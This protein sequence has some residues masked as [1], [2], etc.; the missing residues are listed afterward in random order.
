MAS[1]VWGIAACI[2]EKSLDCVDVSGIA[3]LKYYYEY[4]GKAHLSGDTY[5]LVVDVPDGLRC[6]GQVLPTRAT[7]TP[8]TRSRWPARSTP[9]TTS[10][11]SAVRRERSSGPSRCNGSELHTPGGGTKPPSSSSISR[12]DGERGAVLEIRPDDLDAHRQA[13]RGATDGDD[14]GGKVGQRRQRHPAHHV[15]V[16]P[17]A[18]VRPNHPVGERLAVV[19][20]DGGHHRHR[21]QQGVHVARRTP[22]SARAAARV[23]RWRTPNRGSAGWRSAPCGPAGRRRRRAVSPPAPPGCRIVRWAMVDSRIG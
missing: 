19:V 3:R 4:S 1:W 23:S 13:R 5:T 6:P 15:G 17:A 18:A 7:P 12:A 8:G 14:G 22:P 16:G 11:A 21:H 2:P 20:R 10:A 9:P